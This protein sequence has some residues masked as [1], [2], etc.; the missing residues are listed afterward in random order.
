MDVFGLDHDHGVP[1]RT[2]AGLLGGKGANLTEMRAALGLPVPPGFVLGTTIGRQVLADGWPSALDAVVDEHLTRLEAET[3]RHLGDQHTPLLVA[4]RSGAAVSMPGMMATVLD[5]GANE[6]TVAALAEATG[7]PVFA[8]DTWLRFVRGYATAV[9]GLASAELGPLPAAASVGELAASVSDVEQRVAAAGSPIPDDPRVQVRRA[10]EAAF[11]SWD[12]ERARAY[13]EAEGIDHSLGTAVV[14]QAM[15]FGN[16][17]PRSG[18]GVAFSRDP[19]TGRRSP[20]GDFLAGVQG[21]DVVAGD[22]ITEDLDAMARRLP[23]AH[24]RLLETL[25]ELE[26]HYADLVDVEFTVEEGRLHL[27]QVRVGTRSAIAAARIAIDLALDP[28]VAVDQRSAVQRID[29]DTL[30]RL[31]SMASVQ[32]QAPALASGLPASPGV[33]VGELCTDA[34]EAARRAAEGRAVVLVRPA[35]TPA[36]VHGMIAAVG[37]VTTTGGMVSHTAV[38][39]RGW[40][41]PAV[42]GAGTVEV[43]PG[44]VRVGDRFVGDGR[45]VTVDG[46]SGTVYLDDQR[47]PDHREPPELTRLRAWAAATGVELGGGR[48]GTG[49]ATGAGRHPTGSG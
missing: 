12:S 2:L 45:T 21:D 8:H 9:A 41:I 25:G 33:A 1:A 42:A 23:E 40:G 5:V 15:V 10:I 36:D 30:R 38:V 47:S 20:V 43:V 18:S 31:S 46:G 26:R 14:V 49:P 48:P 32:A 24:R 11:A 4:V 29:A 27:L 7:D 37:L 22:R 39:A 19:A 6:V 34:D 17:G 3:G 44:G 16:L 28:D 13:R 35:T